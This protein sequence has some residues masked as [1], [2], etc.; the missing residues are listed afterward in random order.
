[1]SIDNLSEKQ[2]ALL[3]KL[4]SGVVRLGASSPRI[5][6]IPAG[7]RLPVSGAQRRILFEELLHPGNTFNGTLTLDCRADIDLDAL[8]KSLDFLV[9]RH[10]ILRS[11]VFMSDGEIWAGYN[12]PGPVEF[13]VHSVPIEGDDVDA[14]VAEVGNAFARQHISIFSDAALIKAAVIRIGDD[15][16]LLVLAMHMYAFDAPSG[17]IFAK[18]LA[19]AYQNLS[20]GSAPNLPPIDYEYA[21]LV[22]WRAEHD[23]RDDAASVAFWQTQFPEAFEELRLPVDRARPSVPQFAA[24]RFPFTVEPSLVATLRTLARHRGVSIYVLLLAVLKVTLARHTEQATVAVGA[25]TVQRDARS[26]TLIG[27]LV[28]TLA[29]R[30]VIDRT[31][32]FAA[33]LEEV[34]GV[35]ANAFAHSRLPFERVVALSGVPRD[36]RINPLFQVHFILQEMGNQQ[37]SEHFSLSRF[38]ALIGASGG[39][40]VELVMRDLERGLEGH[41]ECNTALFA[42]EESS[43]LRSRFL[44]VLSQVLE[45]P[46]SLIGELSLSETGTILNGGPPLNESEYL[47]RPLDGHHGIAVVGE[48]GISL[49]S[50]DLEARVAD[51][52]QAISAAV[53]KTAIIG[54]ACDDR[55]LTLIA[56]LSS[57]RAGIPFLVEDAKL[58]AD[59]EFNI[60]VRLISDSQSFSGISLLRVS[61]GGPSMPAACDGRRVAYYAWSSGTAGKRR[62][63]PI[64]AARFEAFVSGISQAYDLDANTIALVHAESSS[65]VFLEETI[66]VLLAG[67]R[68]VLSSSC[69]R[70]VTALSDDIDRHGVTI[71]NVP[72]T[73]WE[74]WFR[75]MQA[76]GADTP[77]TLQRIIVGSDEVS[78]DRLREWRRQFGERV[79]I[80]VAYGVSE[81]AVTSLIYAVPSDPELLQALPRIPVGKP[82]AGQLAFV[83]D[84]AGSPLPPGAVGEI[85]LGHVDEEDTLGTGDFGRVRFDGDIEWLGRMDGRRKRLGRWVDEIPVGDSI[86]IETSQEDRALVEKFLIEL[87]TDVLGSRPS[88]DDNMFD[89]GAVSMDFMR[90]LGALEAR[91]GPLTIA[92]IYD[93]QSI[94]VQADWLA[95]KRE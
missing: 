58:K 72:S 52:A 63:H 68:L 76:T 15:R 32:S 48:N 65:D 12:E 55:L 82:L 11:N 46:D 86:S 13:E 14:R 24:D 29:Y 16:M 49:S 66:P 33:I 75:F 93:R 64:F 20:A 83:G 61:D 94:S 38:D 34:K 79:S 44:C 39:Y 7:E 2:A 85:R 54:I 1:M 78:I 59:I 10:A 74:A 21:D 4:R 80:T 47:V 90:V 70:G 22:A 87:W 17:S 95:Q 28:N 41:F 35:A 88:V 18:E 27:P 40:D 8:R 56:I 45:K 30:S 91:F 23:Q 43:S 51:L 57:I 77:R 5:Q 53:P 9:S 81:H 71:L 50:I 31:K 26:A 92:D 89:L 60:A 84:L 19:L 3:Q 37:S 69:R 73:Y 62:V 6:R 36:S 67:G 25:W 42:P